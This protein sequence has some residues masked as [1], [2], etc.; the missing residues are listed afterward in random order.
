M[1][2]PTRTTSLRRSYAQKLRGSLSELNAAMRRGIV[3]N[4]TFGLQAN[5]ADPPVLSQTSDDEKIRQFMDWL[6]TQ[7]QRGV[8]Q[9]IERDK[10]TF[11]RSAYSKGV[12]HADSALAQQGIEV[13]DEALAAM[14]SRPTH[15]D[16]LQRLYTRNYT[17]LEGITADMNTQI[18]RRLTDGFAR[19]QSSTQIGR[20]ISDAVS[21]IGKNRATT[22]AHTQVIHAHA[23]STLNRFEEFGVDEVTVDAEVLTAGDQRVCPMCG[24]LEGTVMTVEEARSGE[25]THEGETFN[26][27]PPFHPRCRC[28]LLPVVS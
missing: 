2:D 6:E 7:E 16:T 5:V 3:Q 23:E 11:V 28:A 12:R 10:N 20:N 21:S 18:S 26:P 24:S 27:H 22:L 8:L 19:G 15:R 17:D 25:I 4:D 9:V 14:F 1:S 13:P